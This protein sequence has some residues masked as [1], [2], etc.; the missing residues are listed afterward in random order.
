MGV[1]KGNCNECQFQLMFEM[2]GVRKWLVLFR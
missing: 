2:E 1:G